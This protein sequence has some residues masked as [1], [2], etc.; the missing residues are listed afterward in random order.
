MWFRNLQIY[1][2]DPAWQMAPGALEAR[3]QKHL[4]NP[5]SGLNLE[6]RGWVPPL[7]E[8]GL[9]FGAERQM[10]VAFG[11]EKKL[12]PASVVKQAVEEQASALEARQGFKPGRKQL[13]DLKDRVTAELLPRAFAR[14][15]LTRAWIDPDQGWLLVDAASPARAEELLKGLRDALDEFPAHPLEAASSAQG[16]MTQWLT[17]GHAPGRFEIDHEAEL[18]GSGEEQATVRYLRHAL[19]GPDVRRHLDAGKR[20]TRLGLIWNEQLSL[21][22]AEPLQI[23]RLKFLDLDKTREEA[24]SD[25]G[26]DREADFLM[27]SATYQRLLADLLQALGGEAAGR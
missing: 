1:R 7:P 21:L 18:V 24:E 19:N 3:L 5:C 8:A 23:K 27:M 6:T 13:R 10:L 17:G 22:L 26:A 25:V 2:L 12:L 11:Q 4:L 20:V 15:S 16:A 9:V 14:R